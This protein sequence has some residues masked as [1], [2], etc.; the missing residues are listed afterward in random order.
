MRTTKA[1]IRLRSLISTFVI[2][3]LDSIIPLVSISEISSLF[4]A[5]VAEQAGLS[6]PWSQTPKTGF[7]MTW[8]I[9]LRLYLSPLLY[10]CVYIFSLSNLISL[11]L[12]ENMLRQLPAS[13]SFLVKLEILDL[14]SNEID[15]LVSCSS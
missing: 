6:L 15:D 5:S 4:L 12:R 7:L 13:M 10:L 3:C 1:Q 14:G 9:F 8:L 11:E 2:R